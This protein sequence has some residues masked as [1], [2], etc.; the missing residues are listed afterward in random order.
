[1]QSNPM[2]LAAALA[3]RR[4]FDERFAICYLEDR[5]VSTEVALELLT[6]ENRHD[7]PNGY[8]LV[9]VSLREDASP[10]RAAR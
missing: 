5:G 8:F 6:S 4:L 10:V 2:T 3:L 1:M 9:V 7:S